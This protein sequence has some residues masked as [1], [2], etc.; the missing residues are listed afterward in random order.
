MWIWP[1][2]D[3]F[4]ASSFDELHYFGNGVFGYHCI[5]E[6][7]TRL[8][9][10]PAEGR[11][12]KTLLDRGIMNVPRWPTLHHFEKGFTNIS[13]TDGSKY[14]D[15]AKV[16]VH[17]CHDV[18]P[19][20]LCPREYT[21]MRLIR[22]YTICKN[23]GGLQV[24]TEQSLDE[25]EKAILA[26]GDILEDYEQYA[27]SDIKPKDW[28]V[29]KI[30]IQKHIRRDVELKGSLLSM[31]TKHSEK[32]HGPMRKNYL[33]RT[34]FKNVME[35]LAKWDH[36]F[37]VSEVIRENIEAWDK[38]IKEEE[39]RIAAQKKE[40]LPEGAGKHRP[41]A[42]DL[43][44]WEQ[45]YLGAPD[46]VTT[47]GAFEHW[48]KDDV[49]YE[50]FRIKLNNFLKV[51]LNDHANLEGSE[52]KD[53]P[54]DYRYTTKLS[55]K[56]ELIPCRF[57]EVEYESFGTWETSQD[58]LRCNPDFHKKGERYDSVLFRET[59]DTFTF[60]RLI[61]IFICKTDGHRLPMA[62]VQPY[63]G[64][65]ATSDGRRP[66]DWDFQFHRVKLA[67]RSDSRV[68]PL[69]AVERGALL[70]EDPDHEDEYLVVDTVDTDMFL[71]IRKMHPEH[72]I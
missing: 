68:I 48:H 32:F 51:F 19:K 24:H 25:L 38:M 62:L 22:N 60:A 4:K 7:K 55:S 6:L 31:S 72:F 57:L 10:Y 70:T 2:T 41:R 45:I 15:L 65:I 47:Y 28:N 37:F 50:R 29:I 5:K 11:D 17:A 9:E 27:E 23:L 26:F 13:F 30:H 63:D 71:R 64:A 61:C 39:D 34:N 1:R 59:E 18:F 35:Q 66:V 40:D 69:R 58:K 3:P 36:R 14:D 56:D 52:W 54:D 53:E 44:Q 33:A 46:P 67:E 16:M 21:L 42:R 12:F 49:A 43:N 8:K 20:D